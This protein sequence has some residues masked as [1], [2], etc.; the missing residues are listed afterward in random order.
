MITIEDWALL[1]TIA[2]KD[3]EISQLKDEIR[4]LEEQLRLAQID[5]NLLLQKE[6]ALEAEVERYRIDYIKHHAVDYV[7]SIVKPYEE[8]IKRLEAEVEGMKCCGNCKAF[9]NCHF[10]LGGAVDI[11][12]KLPASS[13]CDKWE[14]RK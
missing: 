8:K 13:I 6:V 12:I 9:S 10:M 7:A 3:V 11:G 1:E 5:N 4:R 14:D 2:I